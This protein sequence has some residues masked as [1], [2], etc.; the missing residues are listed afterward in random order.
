V[1]KINLTP[2]KE[3]VKMLLLAVLAAITPG[4][5]TGFWHS[6]PN[7]TEGY[8]SCYFFWN[9]GEYAYLRSIE[10][11]TLYMGDWFITGDELVLNIRDAMTLG[12]ISMGIY[13]YEII[14]DLSDPGGIIPR[15]ILDGESFY[16]L[17]RDPLEAVI[18]LVPTYGMT[19]SEIE[20][21]F[22]YD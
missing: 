14:L 13:S 6:E 9:T 3:G 17:N 19:S 4:G 20:A 18:S 15:I 2:E 12:G 21:F 8:K 16:L 11:G 22:T 1:F 5:L 10:E 7:L